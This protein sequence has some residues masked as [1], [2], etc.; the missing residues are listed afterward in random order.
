MPFGRNGAGQM[1]LNIVDMYTGYVH[2]DQDGV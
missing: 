1:D 2:G